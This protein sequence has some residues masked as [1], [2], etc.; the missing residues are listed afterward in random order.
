MVIIRRTLW[1]SEHEPDKHKKAAQ[2]TAH[3]ATK[4]NNNITGNKATPID[5]EPYTLN[6]GKTKNKI[7]NQHQGPTRKPK[8][9]TLRPEDVSS[10][11]DAAFAGTEPVSYVEAAN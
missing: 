7:L 11:G 8:V 5:T 4:N 6:I 1:A 2:K 10:A 9:S 3:P